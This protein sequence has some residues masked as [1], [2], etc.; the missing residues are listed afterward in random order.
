MTL[1]AEGREEVLPELERT[2]TSKPWL[3]SSLTME[4]PRLPVAPA[5]ATFLY[6]LVYVAWDMCGRGCSDNGRMMGIGE[7]RPI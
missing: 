7:M 1:T 6:A 3:T 2:V 4:G 5:I